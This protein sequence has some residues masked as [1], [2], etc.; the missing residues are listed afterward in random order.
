MKRGLITVFARHKL[1]ANLL[2]V[3]VF[4]LGAVALTR[5]NIQFFPSFA[6][7]YIAVQVVWSGAS[8]EDVENGI[9]IPFEER[10]KTVDGLKRMTSTS[11]QG[12]ASLS[13]ELQEGTDAL[14]AL[15]QVRQRVDEFRNLPKD[16]ETP[17]VSRISRYESVARVL[18]SGPSLQDVRPWVRQFER[19]LLARGVDRVDIAGL[20]QERIAIEV[21]GRTLETLGLSLDGIGQQV[22]R[23]AQDLPSG[24]AGEAD[25]AR[26]L[27]GLE[28]RRDPVAFENLSIVSDERGLVRL[29]DVAVI[30]R[31]SR[32]AAL[33]MTEVETELARSHGAVTVEMLIQ[34]AETG[35]SL[36]AARVF[37]QWLA[38][39]RP[40]LPPSIQLTVFDQAWQL[41]R[42]RIDLLVSNGLQGF[43][44]VLILLYIFL[45]GRVALWVAMGIPTAYLLALALLW[46]FGGT[47]NM[48]SLFALLLTLG[49]I[50]D[51]AIVIGEY[52]ES[53]FRM[54]M[55]PS[56]AA[57]A[58]AKRMFWPV[59]GSA[60][61]TIA[62]FLPLMLVGGIMGN[63][64][65]DI[66]FVAIMVLMASLM[67]VFLI[68]PA[69]LRSAF[70]HQVRQATPRWRK[71][72][73][74]GFDRFRDHWYRPVVVATL[75]WRGVT[76]SAVA[77]MM[78]LSVGLLAGGRIAF[79][80]FPTPEAQIVF[81]N[82]TFV[83]G[84]PR[85]QTAAFLEDLKEALR[86]AERELGGG[87]VEE[88]VARLGATVAVDVGAGARG[89]QLA[90]VL[91]QLV[92]SE[93]RSVRNEAF[94]AKWRERVR[95][96]AGLESLVISSRRSGPPGRDLTVRLTG[97]DA[98]RL[99]S[100]ALDLAQGLESVRGVSDMVDDMPF[101]REQLIYRVSPAGQALGVTTELLGRQL[102]AAFDGYLAQLVQV[103]QDELEVRV[104][105]P[106][107]E[108]TRLDALEQLNIRVPSGEFVPLDTVADWESRRGFEALRHAD[109]RLAVEV[110]ADINR[111]LNTP[112]NVNRVLREGLL[113]DLVERYGVNFSFEGRAADQRETLG[114]MKL[115]L[116]IGLGLI[117]IILAAVFSS[118]GW[119]LV[120]MTAIPLGLIGAIFGHWLLGIDLTLLSMFGL[121][122]L[123]GIVVNNAII[124][125]SMY[126]ELRM[127]GM[128]VNPALEEAACSR[129]RAMLLTSATTVV[130][131]GPLI[132]ATS[133][134]AQFLIPMAVSLAFGI[135]FAT[136]LVLI[137]TP[138]LLSLHESAHER[139]SG[140]FAP[141]PQS[142]ET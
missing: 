77:V 14:L 103:G 39:T 44:L 41:I 74:A 115:G 8:A 67:E 63:I 45:P 24:V 101:G 90:S 32:P 47:I 73:D 75:R 26:E 116:Y 60:L 55:P 104:L 11:T 15:D 1:L 40:T 119:P 61:T 71:R 53:R 131:L 16:A 134:Q 88:A 118:W 20:P 130:G 83:A 122:G 100:A 137:F 34:R 48:M 51:D 57:I 38:D 4:V 108:R 110:S 135:T 124:L 85:E 80:F 82:A 42:D 98:Q 141:A 62:A 109:G 69:H 5:M 76:V 91:V 18:V 79:V 81:A 65:R 28:Q 113:P 58:G 56:E 107:A 23:L 46:A 2:T 25:G 70:S 10:L 3:M 105:L 33:T 111:A 29:G 78:I 87:L 64:L 99:K 52:A 121:F 139:I 22:G 84:T 59:V 128:A 30:V 21:P 37:E 93:N 129:L 27:R 54:G 66:P 49:V 127:T 125:V 120:V 138:A 102:R 13:L 123:S 112:D 9:T 86:A 133:L 136:V 68:M 6:L 17:Q 114:D 72:V 50:D 106:R 31:E 43:V 97:D 94:L 95:V 12:I 89:D 92:P 7:D 126:Q 132:F 19:E 142:A 36:R 96:S 117:Y 140:W 35:H